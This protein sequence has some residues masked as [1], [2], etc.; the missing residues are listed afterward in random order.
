MGEENKT[1]KKEKVI[2]LM[3]GRQEVMAVLQPVNSF[4]SPTDMHFYNMCLSTPTAANIHA[5]VLSFQ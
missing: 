5:S 3:T 1:K 4:L 2:K